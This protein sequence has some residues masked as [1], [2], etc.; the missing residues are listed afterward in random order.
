MFG[1][2]ACS[3]VEKSARVDRELQ[4]SGKGAGG[5]RRSKVR[6][7]ADPRMPVRG[8]R[9]DKKGSFPPLSGGDGWARL[10]GQLGT[11]RRAPL[12][13]VPKRL[14]CGTLVTPEEFL[15]FE[16]HFIA[17]AT[18]HSFS[19]KMRREFL[20]LLEGGNFSICR[21]NIHAQFRE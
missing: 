13:F 16:R 1:E 15:D 3:R 14:H 2:S 4:S 11:A 10:I 9:A 18:G 17:P 20:K 5:N 7:A 6:G 19:E 21:V 12:P 8:Q